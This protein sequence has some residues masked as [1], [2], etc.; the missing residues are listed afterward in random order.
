[1]TVTTPSEKMT[2]AA[3][4]TLLQTAI[5]TGWTREDV[6]KMTINTCT[7]DHPAALPLYQKM[8]FAPVRR[9]ERTRVL[10]YDRTG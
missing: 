5:A 7:L 4:T 1:M 9:Q 2:D 6:E 10:A 3:V 8:G